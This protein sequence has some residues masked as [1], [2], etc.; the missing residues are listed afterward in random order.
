MTAEQIAGLALTLLVMLCGSLASV[1][2]GVPG[3]P[4]I[5][6]AAVLHRLYFG[7]TGANTW[8][9]VLLVGLTLISAAFDYTASVLGAKKLGATWRGMLGALIGGMIGLWF[10]LPG[11][12]LGPFLGAIAFEFAG[13]REFNRAARSGLG[14]VLGLLAGALGKVAICVIMMGLFVVNV[15]YRSLS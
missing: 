9:L 5:L 2:P 3:T 13:A 10:S 7:S 1:L 15:V 14:A 4:L 11:I 6:V 8:V 12:L